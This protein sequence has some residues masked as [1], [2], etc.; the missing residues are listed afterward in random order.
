MKDRTLIYCS[1]VLSI[2]S[3]SYAAWVHH[4]GSEVL[5]AR[6][7]RQR[8]AELVRH[9]APKMDIIYRD[10]VAD[11]KK[12]PKSPTTLEELLDPLVTLMEHIGDPDSGTT[13]KATAK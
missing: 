4:Q 3:L 8:E 13:N 10:M 2:A 11:P 5:A 12:I 6:A 1:L 9:W 7:L